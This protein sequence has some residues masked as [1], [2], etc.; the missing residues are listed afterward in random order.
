MTGSV[1]ES[2]HVPLHKWVLAYRLMNSS[3]K[4][5][6][7]HQLHRTIGVTYKTAWFMAHRIR[8]SMRQDELAP[9]G[10]AG[11]IVEADETYIGTRDGAVKGRGPSHKRVVLTLVERGGEA[12][13][14]HIDRATKIEIV[15]VERDNIKREAHLMTDDAG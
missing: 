4:G 6:S 13:S 14:F 12:R 8:E 10:G 5:V 3:K 11:G 15:P 7:A 9:M 2:S 1:L